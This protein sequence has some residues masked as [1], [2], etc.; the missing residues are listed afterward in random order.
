MEVLSLRMGSLSSV[1][2]L[3]LDSPEEQKEDYRK[4]RGCLD[5]VNYINW[6]L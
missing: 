1:L 5:G 2:L 4:G 6:T 3:D